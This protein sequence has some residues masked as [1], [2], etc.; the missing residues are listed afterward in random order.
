[1]AHISEAAP[2]QISRFYTGLFTFRNP[3]IVPVKMMGR[4]IIE[5]YDAL[6]DGFNMEC[7]NR[8]TLKRRPGYTLVNPTPV[9]GQ[10]LWFYSFKPSDF[11][12]QIFNVVD[13]TADIEYIQSMSIPPVV[14]LTKTTPPMTNFAT[15]AAYLYIAQELIAQKWDSPGGAQGLTKWGI[16]M[17]QVLTG[18]KPPTVGANMPGTQTP[19]A[20]AWTNPGG[21]IGTG[22]FATVTLTPQASVV[23]EGVNATLVSQWLAATGFGFPLLPGNVPAEQVS[24]IQV[25]LSGLDTLQGITNA[26]IKVR[27]L[28]NGALFGDFRKVTLPCN[29]TTITIGSPGDLWN[30]NWQTNDIGQPGFGVAIQAVNS[31][32][33]P[34]TYSVNNVMITIWFNQAPT[35][36]LGAGTLLAQNGYKYVFTYGNSHSGAIS[37]PSPPSVGPGTDGVILPNNNS[38]AVTALASSDPQVTDVH[39]YRTTDGGGSPFFEL[40][41]SPLPNILPVSPGFPTLV[42]LVDNAPDNLLQIAN[43]APAPHFNDAPPGGMVDPVWFAGRLWGHR[44]NKLFFASG[45]DITVGNG[46]EAWYP[47]YVFALPGSEIIRKFPTPNGMLVLTADEIYIVRGFN[48]TSF[49]VN[50]FMRDTGMRTWTAGDSDGT[51]LYLFTSDRQFLLIN[52]NGMSPLASNIA[53]RLL[54]VDPSLA[55]VSQ[56]RYTAQT[57]LLLVGNGSTTLYPLNMELQAWNLPQLPVGGVGAIGSVEVTPGVFQ[58]WRGRPV[59]GSTI[60]FRDLTSFTDEGTPYPAQAIFGPIPVADFLTLAQIR[61]I[62]LTRAPTESVVNV[63]VLAN[64]IVPIAGKQYELMTISSPEPPELSAAPSISFTADRYTW[65]STPLDERVNFFFKRIDFSADP[66]PDEIYSWTAGGTQTTGGSSLGPPG[67]LPQLQGR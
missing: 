60:T 23:S 10:P 27:L 61:D 18:P 46:E 38:V 2:L 33:L 3:L 52:A 22:G 66:Y 50:E 6:A 67:Q 57:S 36:L 21:V 53:D 37:S 45:P 34:A 43:E 42:T 24:G 32:L 8:L 19:P 12:G 4:R 30:G 14:L 54:L 47:V 58:F 29:A 31:S 49:N 15:V 48:T 63:S 5:L 26:G 56:F 39:F 62:A 25:T 51:N 9:N 16:D 1:M 20:P 65:K 11:P 28:R 41:N 40:P 13:T 44:G 59:S 55:Y 64:E 17:A 35:V 7:T